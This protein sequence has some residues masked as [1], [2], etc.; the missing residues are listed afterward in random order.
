[1]KLKFTKMQGAGNDFVVLD[2]VVAAGRARPGAARGGSPTGTSASAATR[3]WWSSGRARPASTS[4]TASSTPTAARSSSA[5]TARAASCGSCATRASRRRARSGSRRSSGVIAPRL[6]DDG[7]VTVDM[8][9]AG[10]RAGARALRHHRP[11]AAARSP[12]ASPLWPLEVA[13]PPTS[14]RSRTYVVSMGNPHAVQIVADVDAAPVATQGP[15]IERHP[16]FPQRVNAG[17]MQVVDRH[18]HRAARLRAR[19]GRDARLRHRRVRGGG[20]RHP[21]RAAR[22]AGRGRD[23]RRGIDD[24]LARRGQSGVHDRAGG[25][26]VRRRDRD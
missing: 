3:S 13:R 23:A 10:V 5:A 19:R 20:R 9:A 6:E 17:Y 11:R 4:A 16:R 15:L 1:M 18:A 24:R 22:L 8:G 7:R 21:A 14:R 2:G 26:R 25:D 12:A